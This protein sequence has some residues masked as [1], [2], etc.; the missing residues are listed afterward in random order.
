MAVVQYTAV[1]NQVRGKLNG[2]VFNKARNAN[3]LQRKQQ[4]PKGQRGN[5]SEVRAEFN[6]AQRTWKLLPS[7]TKSAWALVAANNPDRDRFGD[8]VVLSGYNKYLQARMN[9]AYNGSAVSNPP[10]TASEPPLSVTLDQ[11][12]V[13]TFTVQPDGTIEAA[14]LVNL[15]WS[16]RPV[17]GVGV[18][19]SLPV[20]TGVTRYHKRF[21]SLGSV[22]TNASLSTRSF[23]KNIGQLF[24][25]PQVG[26]KVIV[27]LTVVSQGNGVV[28]WRAFHEHIY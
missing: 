23:S 18:A 27:R 21:V 1:V 11:S 16:G 15:S 13:P 26:Q 9:T 6:S 20:S 19:I 5:Q 28:I 12:S 24:P 25:I 4:Q 7:A 2:S 14:L 10:P 17:I 8:Q 22:T 3:T